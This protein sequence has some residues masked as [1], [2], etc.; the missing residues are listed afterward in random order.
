MSIAVTNG[1]TALNTDTVGTYRRRGTLTITGLSEGANTVPHGLSFTPNR[2]SLRPG[3]GGLWGE[4]SA[5]TST[6]IYITV[7]SGGATAGKV[8]Y[9]E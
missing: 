1:S 5:P 7:G 2:L 4:T 9:S 3:G 8:D 6:N